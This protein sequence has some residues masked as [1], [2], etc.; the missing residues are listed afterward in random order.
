MRR[1]PARCDEATTVTTTV[2]TRAEAP[3]ETQR[4]GADVE[5]TF[6]ADTALLTMGDRSAVL[7]LLV[8][9]IAV[10]AQTRPRLAFAAPF[11]RSVTVS[12]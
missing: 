2:H 3:V 8:G 5:V 4:Y 7:G 1:T 11:V 6:L 12:R 10:A 9:V